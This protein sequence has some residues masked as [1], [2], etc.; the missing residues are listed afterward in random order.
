MDDFSSLLSIWYSKNRRILPW[1]EDPTPYHVYLSEIMLQQTRVSAVIPYYN[2][3]LNAF[4]TI[5]SLAKASEDEVNKLWEGLGYYSRAKNLRKSAFEIMT[6]HGGIFPHTKRELEKLPGIGEYTS[7]AILSIAFEEPYI[8]VDGNLVRIYARLTESPLESDSVEMKDSARQFFFSRLSISPSV[9]NQALMDLGELVCLPNGTPRCVNCPF[10]SFCKANLSSHQY[11]YPLVKEKRKKKAID[12]TLFIIRLG[13]SVLIR[14]R[15]D[16][17]LFASMYELPN[18]NGS[19]TKKEAEKEL[20]REGFVIQ[21]IKML[22]K[23]KHTF[24][25]LI[26]HMQ[27]YL[28]EIS[29]S[30]HDGLFVKKEDLKGKYSLP[31]AFR[32][33]EADFFR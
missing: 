10:A 30:L 25:H 15:A 29:S 23:K 7:S 5:E 3:F 27:A 13:D 14:K 16:K 22:G 21:S 2:R 33:Y 12:M 6:T 8:A 18:V 11:R 24:T 26:W 4:P 1:R 17:G 19:L 31:S 20:I 9:F 28:V 32:H